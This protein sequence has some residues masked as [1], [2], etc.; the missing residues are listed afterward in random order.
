MKKQTNLELL[1]K[2]IRSIRNDRKLTQDEVAFRTGLARSYYGGVER[3]N[4]NIPS[5]NLIKI[6]IALNVEVGELF[7]KLSLLT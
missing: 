6:A 7:P 4:R 1:G 2:Q 3:G 5:E